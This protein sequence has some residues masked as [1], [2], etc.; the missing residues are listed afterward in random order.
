MSLSHV[1]QDGLRQHNY[2]SLVLLVFLVINDLHIQ[3][4]PENRGVKGQEKNSA[5]QR[6]VN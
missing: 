2:E 5:K 6:I 1:Q 4:L 3:H